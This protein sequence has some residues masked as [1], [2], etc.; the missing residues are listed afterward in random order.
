M[1]GNHFDFLVPKTIFYAELTD[2]THFAFKERI[3]EY[4]KCPLRLLQTVHFRKPGSRKTK[5]PYA[6]ARLDCPFPTCS[7]VVTVKVHDYPTDRENFF[8]AL[9]IDGTSNHPQGEY[10]RGHIRG[11]EGEIQD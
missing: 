9:Y 11:S 8:V 7:I 2:N 10:Y 5:S 4:A 6:S 1:S 3:K